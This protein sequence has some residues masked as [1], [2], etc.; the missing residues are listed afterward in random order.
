M[1]KMNT[2]TARNKIKKYTFGIFVSAIFFI[3]FFVSA[4]V[5]CQNDDTKEVTTYSSKDK[6]ESGQSTLYPGYKDYDKC[7][8]EKAP[9]GKVCCKDA[10]SGEAF[11][12]DESSDRGYICGLKNPTLSPTNFSECKTVVDLEAGDDINETTQKVD[13][14]MPVFGVPIPG[15]KF[16][17]I[18]I[19]TGQT[20]TIPWIAEYIIAIYNLSLYAGGIAVTVVIMY[21]GFIWLTSQGNQSTIGRAKDYMANAVLGL[22]I[23]L[24]SYAFLYNINPELV[25]LNGIEIFVLTNSDAPFTDTE[26]SANYVEVTGG[27]CGGFTKFDPG[28]QKQ[29]AEASSKLSS[30]LTCMKGALPEGVGRISGISDSN[31]LSKCHSAWTDAG[32][33]HSSGSCHYGGKCDDGSYAVDFGDEENEKIIVAT[34]KACGAQYIEGPTT[35]VFLTTGRTCTPDSGHKNHVHISV[36]ATSC[37]C[38]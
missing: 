16:S 7:N 14:I 4:E 17:D 29:C 24:G 37:S 18:T 12:L 15:L 25:H 19:Y 35:C 26:V 9:S 28:A 20:V 27:N 5:C 21:A 3:P 34:A 11:L 30:L 10:Q 38:N 22:L 31:G 1:Q 23:L 2:L 32:C 33:H 8:V 13:T 6:C 36:G